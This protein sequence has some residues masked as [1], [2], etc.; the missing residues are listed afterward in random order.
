MKKRK[1]YFSNELYNLRWECA[2]VGRNC[3][4]SLQENTMSAKLSGYMAIII[5]KMHSR[6]HEKCRNQLKL[7]KEMN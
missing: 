4:K 2:S 3:F 7:T 5:N 1:G 6:S